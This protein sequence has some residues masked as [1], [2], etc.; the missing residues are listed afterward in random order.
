MI[1]LGR[2]RLAARIGPNPVLPSRAV[3][4]QEEADV[5][6]S[7]E[8]LDVEPGAGLGSMGEREEDLRA[9]TGMSLSPIGNPA[10]NTIR[11]VRFVMRYGPTLIAVLVTNAALEDIERIPPGAGG[12][13]ACF[14]KHRDTFEQTASAKHGR[15]QQEEDGTIIVQPGDLKSLSGGK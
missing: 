11:G 7:L 12:H 3:S 14:K 1:E 9:D 10:W 4:R 15:G 2:R 13:L 6:R 5:R 8:R